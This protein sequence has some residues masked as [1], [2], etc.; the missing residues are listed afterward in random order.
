M[1]V[2]A[3]VAFA[4]ALLFMPFFNRQEKPHGGSS[5]S[6]Q[7]IASGSPIRLGLVPEYE[8]LA[9]RR[10]YGELAAYLSRAMGR[11][12][13]IVML[14]T[15]EAVLK[16]FEEREV[17]VAFLGSLVAVLAMERHG[18]RVIARP[19]LP[20]SISRYCGVLFVRPDSSLRNLGEIRN[21]TVGMLRATYAGAL[22]PLAELSRFGIGRSGGPQMVWMGTHDEIIEAVVSGAVEVGAVKD[23]RLDAWERAHPG[24]K[25]QRLLTSKAV[26]NSGVVVRREIYGEIGPGLFDALRGMHNH[27]DGRSALARI[28]AVRFIPCRKEEYA[29]IYDMLDRVGDAWKE[30]GIDGPPPRRMPASRTTSRPTSPASQLTVP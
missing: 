30:V 18:A 17:D 26:P 28:N 16:D 6:T 20:G 13:K 3:P 15:Y 29:A 4:I 7:A 11:P 1:L 23:L 19:E 2:L 24:V 27:R 10:S 9:M 25:F 21:Q 22:T 8:P 12:V 14:N 5:A